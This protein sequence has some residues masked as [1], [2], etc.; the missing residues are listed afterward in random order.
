MEEE[1]NVW[2]TTSKA[3]QTKTAQEEQRSHSRFISEVRRDR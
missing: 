3:L 2:E 1:D